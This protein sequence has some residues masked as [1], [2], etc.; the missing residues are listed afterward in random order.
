MS[1]HDDIDQRLRS[2]A[3]R[4]RAKEPPA[5]RVE[6]ETLTRPHR[7]A[8][9][10]L[11]VP[12]AVVAVA[13]T[14][15]VVLLFT[16]PDTQPSQPTHPEREGRWHGYAGLSDGTLG[17]RYSAAAVWTGDVVLV[18]GGAAEGGE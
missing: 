13:L 18:W 14:V 16:R 7:R 3:A 9:T 8:G 1:D 4:W 5:A 11:L 2:Y 10:W 17:L 12:A 6:A 15:L